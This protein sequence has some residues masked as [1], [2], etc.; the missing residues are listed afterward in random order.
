MNKKLKNYFAFHPAK[1]EIFL[2]DLKHNHHFGGSQNN[3]IKHHSSSD[4][5]LIGEMRVKIFLI[6]INLLFLFLG[7]SF[8]VEQFC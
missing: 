3:Q 6:L 2:Y 8:I 1:K 5:N 7:N 4:N